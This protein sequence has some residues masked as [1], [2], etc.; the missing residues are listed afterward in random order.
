MFMPGSIMPD[1]SQRGG[2]P[3]GGGAFEDEPPL[4]EELGINFDHIRQKTLAVLNPFQVSSS[5]VKSQFLC[6]YCHCHSRYEDLLSTAT[7]KA[8]P[9]FLI[10]CV[11]QVTSSKILYHDRMKKSIIMID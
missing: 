4:L 3:P 1:G 5:E 11:Y 7:H 9:N 10:R 8:G 6:F 2:S